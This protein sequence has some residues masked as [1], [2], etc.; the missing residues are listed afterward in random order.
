MSTG[1]RCG[2]TVTVTLP[3]TTGASGFGVSSITQFV[4]GDSGV[5]FEDITAV[6]SSLIRFCFT[7]SS[8]LKWLPIQLPPIMPLGTFMVRSTLGR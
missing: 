5:G 1:T 8:L 2:L 7:R 6:Y 4:S 3:Q